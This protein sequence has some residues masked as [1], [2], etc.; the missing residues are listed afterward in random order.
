[1]RALRIGPGRPPRDRSPLPPRGLRPAPDQPGFPL[2]RRVQ[3]APAEATAAI[4]RRGT[5]PGLSTEES[6]ELLRSMGVSAD[7][8]HRMSTVVEVELFTQRQLARRNL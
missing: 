1:M 5:Y 6:A 7:Y 4:M 8:A 3:S 2:L